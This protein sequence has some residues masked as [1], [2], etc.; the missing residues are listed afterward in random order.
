MDTLLRKTITLPQVDTP[1]MV[2][3]RP[4][5]MDTPLRRAGIILP[6]RVMAIRLNKVRRLGSMGGWGPPARPLWVSAAG[7]LR[8]L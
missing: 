6:R 7:C 2:L 4:R 1:D 5:G 3:L 8:G